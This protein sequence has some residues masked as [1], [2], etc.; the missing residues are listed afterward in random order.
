[1]LIASVHDTLA[2]FDII[3]YLQT[4]T[5]NSNLLEKSKKVRVIGISSYRELEAMTENK[6]LGWRSNASTMLSVLQGQQEVKEY[7]EKELNNK[8]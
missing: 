8:A 3:C 1:M 5:D 2:N 4:T 7:F 6:E